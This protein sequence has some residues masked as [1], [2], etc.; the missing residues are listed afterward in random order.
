MRRPSAVKSG[1]ALLSARYEHGPEPRAGQTPQETARRA[2][3]FP[4]SEAGVAATRATGGLGAS[5]GLSAPAV[6]V[7]ILMQPASSI[8]HEST[9]SSCLLSYRA[10]QPTVHCASPIHLAVQAR[11]LTQSPLAAHASVS[12]RHDVVK[13]AVSTSSEVDLE[14]ASEASSFSAPASCGAPKVSAAEASTARAACAHRLPTPCSASS[15]EAARAAWGGEASSGGGWS[16]APRWNP[17]AERLPEAARMAILMQKCKM[18]RATQDA[19]GLARGGGFEQG[20]GWGRKDG[21]ASLG[22]A[23]RKQEAGKPRRRASHQKI[24]ANRC[25]L[26]L[27]RAAE[28]TAHASLH[29]RACARRPHERVRPALG[30]RPAACVA[31]GS[32]GSSAFSRHRFRH[33]RRYC[34]CCCCSWSLPIAGPLLRRRRRRAAQAA[35]QRD[36]AH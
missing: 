19:R 29:S 12:R 33:W 14:P 8:V 16:G 35:P 13:Q 17:A 5:S 10:K 18:L 28:S 36:M 7:A 1:V 22:P 2:H 26:A 30:T 25:E 32:A 23:G 15:G 6:C 34:C 3:H 31:P 27:R 9:S 4:S 11:P 24:K 21:W 20:R